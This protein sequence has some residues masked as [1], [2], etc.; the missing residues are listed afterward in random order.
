MPEVK[1]TLQSLY[2][3]KVDA[4]SSANDIDTFVVA[5]QLHKQ[6][7]Y[8]ICRGHDVIG[9]MEFVHGV[10][11]SK[12]AMEDKMKRYYDK[13][14]FYKTQLFAAVHQYCQPFGI[15]AHK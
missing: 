12:S 8:D 1:V 14:D 15:N 6:S 3:S 10:N 2:V 5:K 7:P 9:L 11:Y 13:A 4:G